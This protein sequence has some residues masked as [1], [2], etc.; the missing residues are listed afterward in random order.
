M[1][2]NSLSIKLANPM[3]V[4]VPHWGPGGFESADAARDYLTEQA[5]YTLSAVLPFAPEGENKRLMTRACEAWLNRSPGCRILLCE[6]ILYMVYEYKDSLEQQAAEEA[7]IAQLFWNAG[8]MEVYINP[9][10]EEMKR[11]LL[12]NPEI[13]RAVYAFRDPA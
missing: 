2:W 11:V 12:E 10:E 6:Y 9:I 3:P 7:T 13:L 4:C 8:E 1:P 5:Q